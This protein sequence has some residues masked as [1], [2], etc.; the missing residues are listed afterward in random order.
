MKILLVETTYMWASISK[1][2]AACYLGI[3]NRVMVNCVSIRTNNHTVSHPPYG[4]HCSSTMTPG[5]QVG[6]VISK[7]LGTSV[8]D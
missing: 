6:A 4:H 8:L 7:F 2:K 3:K 1:M 5:R